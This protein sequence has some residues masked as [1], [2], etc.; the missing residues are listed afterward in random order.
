MQS[1]LREPGPDA[2]EEEVFENERYIPLRGWGSRG[3]LL[4]G[5]RR[6]YSDRAGARSAA[7]FPSPPLP[8]GAGVR[9]PRALCGCLCRPLDCGTCTTVQSYHWPAA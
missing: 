4:P 3:A 9:C 7:E 5:E 2:A 8:P 1:Q 6:R